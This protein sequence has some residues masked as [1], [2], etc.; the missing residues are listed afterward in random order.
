MCAQNLKLVIIC[1]HKKR[2]PFVYCLRLLVRKMGENKV[3][4]LYFCIFNAV[5]TLQYEVSWR[6]RPCFTFT[7]PP[8]ISQRH[9][10]WAW[11]CGSIVTLCYSK[12]HF[13]VWCV[14]DTHSPLGGAVVL[15]FT[16]VFWV[17]LG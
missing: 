2:K 15:C 4:D 7:H 12:S 14:L 3:L 11:Q 16:G 9:T 10:W 6:H 17:T 13:H 8:H 5:F 1:V